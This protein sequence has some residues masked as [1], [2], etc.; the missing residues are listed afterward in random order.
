MFTNIR[1]GLLAGLIGL[2]ALALTACGGA[3]SAAVDPETRVKSFFN[4]FSS[5]LNDQDIA[6]PAKQEEWAGKLAGYAKPDQQVGMKDEMKQ[7]LEQFGGIGTS[8]GALA[9]GQAN[10]DIKLNVSFQNIETKLQSQSGNTAKVELTGGTLKM[11]LAGKDVDKLGDA[12]KTINQELPISEF[13]KETTGTS[14]NVL[15]LELIDGVWYM[16]DL[17]NK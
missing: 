7:A 11:A 16:A 1:R 17:V 14:S 15:T 3:P 6:K 9:G 10:L 2:L 4:D 8:L 5:A 13:F 12:A